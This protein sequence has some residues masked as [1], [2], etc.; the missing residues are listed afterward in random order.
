VHRSTSPH[1][2]EDCP[3]KGHTS[4]YISTGHEMDQVF[5]E[6]LVHT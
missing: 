6:L 4:K 1:F 2:D 3:N 5:D